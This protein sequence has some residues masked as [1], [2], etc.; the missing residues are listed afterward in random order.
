[1]DKVGALERIDLVWKDPASS[2]SDLAMEVSSCV[3]EAALD[4]DGVAA[5]IG[6]TPSEVAALLALSELDE[7]MLNKLSEAKVPKTTWSLFASANDDEFE[8]ALQAYLIQRGH[9]K[10]TAS[11]CVYRS[12]VS[13]SGPSLEQRIGALSGSTIKAVRVRAEQFNA[14]P[15]KQVKFLKSIA[16][17]RGRGKVLTAKQVKYLKDIL[18]RLVDEGIISRGGIDKDQPIC[19]EVLDVLEGARARV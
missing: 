10:E 3:S 15:D 16:A 8:S 6:A 2:L 14:L 13:V 9:V 11:E 5:Y 19:D 18:T 7:I 1:M 4:A 17:S 12:M